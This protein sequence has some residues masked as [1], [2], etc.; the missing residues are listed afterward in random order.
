MERATGTKTARERGRG[1]ARDERTLSL[2]PTRGARGVG[3][4]NETWLLNENACSNLCWVEAGFTSTDGS[5]TYYFRENKTPSQPYRLD[6]LDPV[7]AGD[8]NG[9]VN[10]QIVQDINVTSWYNV[11][12]IANSG[13]RT[14]TYQQNPWFP[15]RIDIGEELYGT[16]GAYSPQIA[17]TQ[18]GYISA[19]GSGQLQGY[20]QNRLPDRD[21][22]GNPPYAGWAVGNNPAQSPTGGMWLAN[23]C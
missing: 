2:H 8:Y 7:P 3:L 6:I 11:Y 21:E 14:F 15:D 4:N 9:T 22:R 1:A 19:N 5:T 12:I 20:Y 13:Q 17:W 18:N 10:V 23:C 16:S